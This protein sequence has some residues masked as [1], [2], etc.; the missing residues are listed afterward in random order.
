M[1]IFRNAVR[2]KAAAGAAWWVP[3]RGMRRWA[4]GHGRGCRVVDARLG[5]AGQGRLWP[6]GRGAGRGDTAAPEE[7]Q[8]PRTRTED[9]SSP[10][11]QLK[12]P[13]WKCRSAAS[14]VA[15]PA[16]SWSVWGGGQVEKDKDRQC[17]DPPVVF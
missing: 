6:G 17:A 1:N 9:V 11:C 12:G 8:G 5:F 14:G 7:N 3:G 13:G 10:P 4:G 2:H 15:G 16:W